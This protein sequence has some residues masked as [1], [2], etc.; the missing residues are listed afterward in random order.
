MVDRLEERALPTLGGAPSLAARVPV[1][2]VGRFAKRQPLGAIGGV[3]IIV[4]TLVA[5]LAPVIAPFGAKE[6]A[7]NETGKITVYASPSSEYLLGTDEVGRDT[8]SRLI[9]GARISLYVAFGSVLI[10]ITGFFILGVVSAYAG[11]LF[12]L[13]VQRLVD[14]KMALPGLVIALAIM[15]VLGPSLNNVIIAIIIGLAPAIVRTVRSQVLSLKEM[16][17]VLAARALGASPARIVF[18]HI[19]PN[20]FAIYLILATYYLGFAII[21]EASLSFLGVGAPPDEPSWGGMLTVAVQE[22]FSNYWVGVFP[23]LAIFIVVLGFNFLG[24][25]LRDI[26]DPR[27]RNRS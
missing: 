12:D 14:T 15:A 5:L 17:Y 24:D 11:G 6:L 4:V 9:Y 27:L 7:R 13:V 1:K 25:A 22:Y 3:I 2:A 21:L 18:R 16:D 8:L 10:G 23:G 19:A 26:M 20:C